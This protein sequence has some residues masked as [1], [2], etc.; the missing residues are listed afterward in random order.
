M[1][2]P[3]P[4]LLSVMLFSSLITVGCSSHQEVWDQTGLPAY[5]AGDTES[6]Q[7]VL[8]TILTDLQEGRSAGEWDYGVADSSRWALE[9]A[10]VKLA[11]GDP[12]AA[13]PLLYG[14]GDV[15]DERR[16]DTTLE[17]MGLDG[18][19]VVSQL[20]TGDA[21][22]KFRPRD[23]EQLM[24]ILLLALCDRVSISQDDAVYAA[25]FD[26]VQER[27]ATFDF[28]ATASEEGMPGKF[29]PNTEFQRV[30]LGSYL[31]GWLQ[32]DALNRGAAEIAFRRASAYA[33]GSPS[34]KAALAAVDSGE[35]FY[36]KGHGALHVVYLGGRGPHV[37]SSKQD[38]TKSDLLAEGIVRFLRE[39]F[40][41]ARSHLGSS[42]YKL[43]DAVIRQLAVAPI[44]V[45]YVQEQDQAVPS[46]QVS[47]PELEISVAAE[48]LM[49]VNELAA[50]QI[51]AERMM[52]VCR[53]ILR[54][55]LKASLAVNQPEWVRLAV[56][57]ASTYIEDADTR[58]WSTL[59]AQVQVARLVVP[60]GEHSFNLGGVEQRVRI[61]AHREAFAV[62]V[63]RNL[64]GAA[65][66]VLERA[67]QPLPDAASP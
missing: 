11:A 9:S 18:W 32:A 26:L 36:P 64:A 8:D 14:V 22:D 39:A 49:D 24:A 30:A 3:W 46:F 41:L 4:L 2:T 44:F 15:L 16:I 27:I 40:E 54:R 33:P 43:T 67:A 58:V 65:T 23:Y 6:A 56:D 19:S 62:V 59:P 66:V 34:V 47:A 7:A 12:E 50:Q 55:A 5:D 48:S 29:K 31:Q 10:M 38:I 57:A 45:R 37:G 21:G 42:D 52:I 20:L 28:A 60:E 53:A 25:E 1:K 63:H 61:A 51:E 13:L 35:P 17:Y